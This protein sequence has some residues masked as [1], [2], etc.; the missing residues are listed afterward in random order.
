VTRPLRFHPAVRGEVDD[1][2]QWDEQRGAG[3]GREFLDEVGRAPDEIA[4]NPSRFGFAEADI[5]EG[6]LKRFPYAIYYREL[7]DHIRVLAVYQT[8]RDPAGWP[9]R[10]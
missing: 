8:A 10:N 9:A 4:A 5:R 2:Y 3:L 7:S 6:Q 1:A